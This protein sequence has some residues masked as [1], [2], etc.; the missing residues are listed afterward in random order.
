MSGTHI[1][2]ST[3]GEKNQDSKRKLASEGHSLSTECREGR[4]R[5]AEE[6]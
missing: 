1:L 4:V 3:K 6:S 5:T 2:S